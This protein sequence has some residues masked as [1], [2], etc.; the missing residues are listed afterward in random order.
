MAALM[1]M[2]GQADAAAA[3]RQVL[4]ELAPAPADLGDL[5]DAQLAA[6]RPPTPTCGRTSR[7][8]TA[9]RLHGRAGSAGSSPSAARALLG[10]ARARAGHGGGPHP[11]PLPAR[12]VPRGADDRAAPLRRGRGERRARARAVRRGRGD[13]RVRGW[14]APYL[15]AMAPPTLA[16]APSGALLATG[17][18][19]NAVRRL[20]E[21]GARGSARTER[22]RSPN[23]R[24]RRAQAHRR[25]DD[26][27]VSGGRGDG[28]L[29]PV[30]RRQGDRRCRA[31]APRLAAALRPR[32]S[33][34]LARGR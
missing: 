6:A 31:D 21:H 14:L 32:R 27:G 13:R 17:G 34:R 25:G 2:V 24:R 26:R 5:L 33:G 15:G 20:C 16:V 23:G 10:R 19:V 12:S 30:E 3:L 22:W 18:A 7:A 11:R 4:A 29:V 9:I 1:V 28:A 8:A